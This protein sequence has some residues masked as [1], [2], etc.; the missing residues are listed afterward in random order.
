[1]KISCLNSPVCVEYNVGALK[2]FTLFVLLSL[3]IPSG[4]DGAAEASSR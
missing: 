4:I 1:M 3:G 2:T